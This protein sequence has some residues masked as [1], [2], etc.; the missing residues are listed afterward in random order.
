MA[1]LHMLGFA[2]LLRQFFFIRN[3]L[4]SFGV[5]HLLYGHCLLFLF[6]VIRLYIGDSVRNLH[7]LL[8]VDTSSLFIQLQLLLHEVGGLA[9]LIVKFICAR[10]QRWKADIAAAIQI[11][12]RVIVLVGHPNVRQIKGVQGEGDF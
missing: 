12:I 4:I 8:L 2:F 6:S 9:V 3:F 1:N 11:R 10:F 5:T 7:L